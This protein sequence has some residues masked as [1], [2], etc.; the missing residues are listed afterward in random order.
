MAHAA[1][2]AVPIADKSTYT[3]FNRTPEAQLRELSTDR[4]DITESPY[5]VDAG[6]FQIESDFLAY[7]R[8]HDTANGADVKASA[9]SV[10]ALNFKFGLTSNM[11]L[12]TVVEPYVRLKAD[13][14]KSGQ[15]ARIAGF[16]D[17]TSR[18][19]INF[20]GNDGGDSALGLMPF[21][22]WP[23]SHR[24]LGTDS[25]EGGLIIP[26]AHKLPAGWDVGLMT[27]VDLVRSDDDD[28]YTQEWTNS[29]TFGH[30]IAYGFG[31]Y[32]EL[33]STVG[34][35]A[36]QLSFDFGA[37]Y[38]VGEHGQLDVGCNVGLTRATDDLTIFAGWSVRF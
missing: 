17:I 4:P 9:L 14:K 23:T 7:S 24:G 29:I 6:W 18:L 38:G 19:K 15:H 36:G 30:D 21:V 26:Y 5:T 22:T 3:I 34:P 33:A 13:D 35:G 2:A 8:S 20:W 27:E 28:G 32:M 12:Q 31:G 16:G 1:W 10:A 25:V 11:D 37:T